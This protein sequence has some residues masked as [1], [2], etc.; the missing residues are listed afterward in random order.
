MDLAAL[1]QRLW[2]AREKGDS[3][4]PWLNGA[5]TLKQALDVQ[6]GL[7]GREIERGEALGGW[8]VGLTSERARK[9]LGVDARPFGRVL[10]S[11]IFASRARVR[12]AEIAHPSIEPELCFTIGR[13]LAGASPSR[14]EVAAA[15][16]QVSAGFELNERRAVS[17]RP[18]FPALVTDC[19]THWG[20]V[21]GSGVPLASLDLG[22][23]RCELFRDGERVYAGV[24]R[25]ELDDHLDSLC[26]L[27]A[28][29]AAHGRVLEPGQRVITGAF[30]R[31]STA[32]GQRWR[33]IYQGVGE[34]EVAFA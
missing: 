32:A 10:A 9:A 34:V 14:E 8:K 29:L 30:A 26:R 22:G 2:D 28:G 31:E 18:D 23:V 25:E 4:P 7:L 1:T 21:V 27:A 13:R 3:C 19:L 20:I 16:A 17:A 15:I 6:L 5:L 33:A 24:S 12:A 11:R